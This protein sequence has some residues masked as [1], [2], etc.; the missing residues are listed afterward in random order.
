MRPRTMYIK[1]VKQKQGVF[2]QFRRLLSVDFKLKVGTYY[3]N[4][5][6]KQVPI[7]VEIISTF[8]LYCSDFREDTESRYFLIAMKCLNIYHF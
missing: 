3:M 4:L 5:V 1:H 7:L 8:V 2:L 6:S